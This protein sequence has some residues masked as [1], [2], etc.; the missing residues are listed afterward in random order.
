SCSS[1]SFHDSIE[2]EKRGVETYIVITET[3]LPLVRAQA[4]ARKADPKLLI[5]K[6]PV[7]G[8]NAEELAERIGVASGELK[9]AV[10]A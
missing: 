1:W 3:F 10:N 4:K 9:Q 2:L 8:L 5:V 7:G 6:H